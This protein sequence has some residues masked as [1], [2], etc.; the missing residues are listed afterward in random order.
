MAGFGQRLAAGDA[1]LAAEV[2]AFMIRWLADHI[3]VDDIAY[4][5]FL[6]ERGVR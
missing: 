6:Q 3:L 2:L 1:T 5:G 4:S